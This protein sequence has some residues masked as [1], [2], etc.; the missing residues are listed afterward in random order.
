MYNYPGL[1]IGLGKIELVLLKIG[2]VR[3]LL[4]GPWLCSMGGM[5]FYL[6]WSL[7]LWGCLILFREGRGDVRLQVRR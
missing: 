1:L 4:V 7:A 5:G 3:I 2:E 6:H